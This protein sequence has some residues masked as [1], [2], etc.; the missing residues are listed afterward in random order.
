MKKLFIYKNEDFNGVLVKNLLRVITVH[1]TFV[2]IGRNRNI[3]VS[4]FRKLA[5][6]LEPN[7]SSIAVIDA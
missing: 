6:Y 7:F 2:G 1:P 5:E 4:E 3:D